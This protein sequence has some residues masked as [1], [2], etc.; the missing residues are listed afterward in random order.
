[1]VFAIVIEMN[2]SPDVVSFVKEINRY[3]DGRIRAGVWSLV[4]W[5]DLPGAGVAG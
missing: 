2:A 1:M 3:L 4:L 5:K